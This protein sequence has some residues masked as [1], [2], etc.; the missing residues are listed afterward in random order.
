[1]D[2]KMNKKFAV[3]LHHQSQRRPTTFFL[4]HRRI[5]SI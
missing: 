1:M 4:F 5:F 3:L 2:K